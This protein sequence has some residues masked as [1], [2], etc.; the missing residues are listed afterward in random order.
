MNVYSIMRKRDF[1][2]NIVSQ[3]LGMCDFNY[4]TCSP[5]CKCADLIVF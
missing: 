2:Y 3:N 4:L 1:I 5:T